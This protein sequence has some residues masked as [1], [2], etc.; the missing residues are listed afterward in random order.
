MAVIGIVAL[1]S[2][3]F[4]FSI[5]L[6]EYSSALGDLLTEFLPYE[7]INWKTAYVGK[8]IYLLMGACLSTLISVGVMLTLD[9]NYVER[10]RYKELDGDLL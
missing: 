5:F 3:I 4:A 6:L 7:T 8:S 2:Y 1:L 10:R 9:R